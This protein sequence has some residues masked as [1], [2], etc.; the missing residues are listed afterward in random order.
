MMGWVLWKG[1]GWRKLMTTSGEGGG[2]V[3]GCGRRCTTPL[4][5]PAAAALRVKGG[6]GRGEGGGGD[7]HR[8]HS[9]VRRAKIATADARA[10][11]VGM[12][13]ARTGHGGAGAIPGCRRH[14]RQGVPVLLP[15]RRRSPAPLLAAPHPAPAQR[16]GIWFLPHATKRPASAQ[17][18][19]SICLFGPRTE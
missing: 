9:S 4:P 5:R 1:R 11:V 14:G 8:R 13:A 17:I 12:R 18:P 15:R 10:H 7:R 16:G 3:T 2:G 6:G 19:R